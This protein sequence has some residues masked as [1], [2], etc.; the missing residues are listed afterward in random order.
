MVLWSV[1]LVGLVQQLTANGSAPPTTYIL[2]L[3]VIVG[4]LAGYLLLSIPSVAYSFRQNSNEYALLMA[5]V[6]LVVIVPYALYARQDPD[7]DPSILLSTAMLLFLPVACALLNTPALKRSDIAT[8]LV[9]VMLPLAVPLIRN[10]PITTVD[11]AMRLGAMALPILLLV[12]TTHTQKQ[13]LNF[14]FVCGVL[15]LWYSA[16]FQA[17]PDYALPNTDNLQYFDVILLPLLLLVLALADRF[18][19]LGLSFRPSARGVGTVLLYGVIA[20]VL[21]VPLGLFSSVLQFDS[22]TLQ[23]TL[24][25]GLSGIA[26]ALLKLLNIFLFVALPEELLFR[27]S[28]L[29]YLHDVLA[30]PIGQAIV[31]SSLFFGLAH[32]QYFLNVTGTVSEISVPVTIWVGG[33]AT[34]A[35]VV[36]ALTF[37]TRRNVTAA[38]TVHALINWIGALMFRI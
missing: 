26:P 36:Y 31:I 21:L 7:F 14:L 38:A 37:V 33:I 3:I 22:A 35:G 30:W 16:Q 32:L 4:A 18:T 5:V 6:P 11:G 24:N 2:P 19:P 28:I 34:V 25:A 9:T 1:T 12:L 10:E 29:T 15:S 17:L 27:G 13:R 20:V 23:L 8:G